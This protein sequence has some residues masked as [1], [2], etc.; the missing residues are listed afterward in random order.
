[1]GMAYENT[2][3]WTRREIAERILQGE[4]L[5]IYRGQLLKIPHSWL[6]AHPGGS[7]AILHFVGRDATDEIDAFH[8]E[9]TM[10]SKV[11]NYLVGKVEL[12]A[13]GL[14]EPL[15]PPV[16]LGWVWKSHKSGGKE[17]EW[18]REAKART[19]VEDEQLLSSEILL[20]GNKDPARGLSE[21]R[22]EKESLAPTLESLQ[23]PPPPTVISL[24]EQTDHSRA[25]QELH[26]QIIDA[27]LYETP[28]LS[29]YGPEIVRYLTG[30][31]LSA[32]AFYYGWYMT[33]AFFLGLVWHQLT[34][35]AH[36]LGHMG[37]TH[38]WALDRLIGIFVADFCGGLSIGWWVDN[39]N[40][41]HLVPNHPTHDPDIQHLPFFAISKSFLNNLYSS[42]YRRIMLFDAFATFVLR[43]QHQLYYIIMSFARFN[44]Y[45]NSYGFLYKRAFDGKR[46][47]GGKWTFYLEVIA[48]AMFWMWYGAL[49]AHIGD[50]KRIL[51]FVLISHMVPSPLHVQ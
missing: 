36:D 1:M 14:W 30:Y 8:A 17:G 49:L 27:G 7:L 11:K 24:Q 13:R 2:A 40:I 47:R 22:T 43:F 18:V 44:L 19:Q 38:D 41:H 20:V 50:W 21:K 46:A 5:V 42:Y 4:N 51:G 48:I 15:T 32:V 39:H 28:Y 34:F 29:G 23:P 25:F 45:A 10:G 33:S 6:Q 12:S 26:Q 37:V 3:V 35:T 16:A 9:E 31:A